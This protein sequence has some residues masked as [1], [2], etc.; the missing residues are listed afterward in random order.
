[1]MPTPP[2]ASGFDPAIPPLTVVA[3]DRAVS[4]AQIHAIN[5]S[6]ADEPRLLPRLAI[7]RHGQ[8]LTDALEIAAPSGW[9]KPMTGDLLRQGISIVV[10]DIPISPFAAAAIGA[11][12]G[13]PSD[14]IAQ[15]NLYITPQGSQGFDP[16]CDPHIV[17]VAHLYG[18]K[19]W[20]IYEKCDINP[21]YDAETNTVADKG[22]PLPEHCRIHVKPGDMF[23]IPRGRYHA[24]VASSAAS[25]HLAI[26]AAGARP[27]DHLWRLAEDS[28]A[29][30]ALR[31]DLSPDAALKAA[32]DYLARMAPGLSPLKLP[33]FPRPTPRPGPAPASLSLAPIMDALP[34][35]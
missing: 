27:I 35:A 11:A 9:F 12:T 23:W 24:A 21:I 16:H 28:L 1:M 31:A 22:K 20:V 30:P 3:M 2:A 14:W 33:R 29:D 5:H 8:N 19:E 6:L 4:D 26:G 25:V 10:N 17:I 34:T 7:V 15:Q 32:Q 18:E 13:I